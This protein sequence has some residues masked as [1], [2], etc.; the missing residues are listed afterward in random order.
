MYY[1]NVDSESNIDK[2][3]TPFDLHYLSTCPRKSVELFNV[4]TQIQLINAN[5]NTTLHSCSAKCVLLSIL[6]FEF[7]CLALVWYLNGTVMPALCRYTYCHQRVHQGYL[8]W[9]H[10]AVAQ[11]WRNQALNSQSGSFIQNNQL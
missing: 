10:P 2:L 6:C 8:A 11:T 5:I 9:L 3:F 1:V 7:A 4:A